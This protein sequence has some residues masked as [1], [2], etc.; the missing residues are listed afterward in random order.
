MRRW[1][2]D[3]ISGFIDVVVVVPHFNTLYDAVPFPLWEKENICSYRN[4]NGI[5]NCFEYG[6]LVLL[7]VGGDGKGFHTNMYPAEPAVFLVCL[8]R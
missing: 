7:W 8:K 6:G 5:V 1:T 2:N 4:Y 3:C